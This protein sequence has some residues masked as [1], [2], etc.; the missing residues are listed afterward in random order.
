MQVGAPINGKVERIHKSGYMKGWPYVK[1][2]DDPTKD[3][4]KMINPANIEL[5]PRS[6]AINKKIG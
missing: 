2:S 1:W 5:D 3:E 6:K 4:P